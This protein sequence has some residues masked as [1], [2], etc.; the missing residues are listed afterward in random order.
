V[1]EI[2]ERLLKRLRHNASKVKEP[3]IHQLLVDSYD[4]INGRGEDAELRAQLEAALQGQI[5]VFEGDDFPT[6]RQGPPNPE[7]ESLLT[8]EAATVLV[9]TLKEV[10]ATQDEE[11]YQEANVEI[12][13]EAVVS[14]EDQE[15]LDEM[16]VMVQQFE[17][18]GFIGILETYKS[19]KHKF[20]SCIEP[21]RVK[22]EII[23]FEV[24]LP[25]NTVVT[26]RNP[27][28]V[29]SNEKEGG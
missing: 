14:T 8:A 27:E 19:A 18:A 25:D 6:F 12:E 16:H 11:D 23:A 5:A 22:G 1:S 10:R 13:E 2:K 21:Q 9:N 4:Y 15:A 20:P 29:E 7:M 26:L 28:C 3:T 17:Q 24:T